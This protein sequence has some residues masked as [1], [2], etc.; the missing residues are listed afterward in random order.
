MIFGR[1][2]R[3]GSALPTPE[4]RGSEFALTSLRLGRALQRGPA[5]PRES[6]VGKLV[7]DCALRALLCNRGAA[8]PTGKLPSGLASRF[9]R[10]PGQISWPAAD[11]GPQPAWAS[12]RA[13]PLTGIARARA[14]LLAGFSDALCTPCLRRPLSAACPL[15]PPPKSERRE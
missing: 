9:G 15:E 13:P 12:P 11:T 10:G 6:A 7:G 8:S 1:R 5:A 3:L 14:L 4:S 2:R